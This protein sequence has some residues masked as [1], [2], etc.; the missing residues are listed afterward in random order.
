MASKD[1]DTA[2][3]YQNKD[4]VS[5]LFGDRMKGKPLSLFG[6]GT[7]LRVVDVRPTNIPIVQARELKMDNL[8]V[9]EDGSV[10]VLDYESE[11]RKASFAK[12]GRYIL[13]VLNGIEKTGRSRIS[14]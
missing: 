5:K 11:Y 9:L 12:Y 4:I 6:L 8:F 14:A 2:I 7:D 10:A 3:A 1:T 13:G